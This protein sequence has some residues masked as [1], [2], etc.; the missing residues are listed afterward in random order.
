MFT[1]CR[2]KSWLVCCAIII[3]L[4]DWTLEPRELGDHIFKVL[5]VGVQLAEFGRY[6]GPALGSVRWN[7]VALGGAVWICAAL[8]FRVAHPS[9]PDFLDERAA[10]HQSVNGF[11]TGTRWGNTFDA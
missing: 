8:V 2:T 5:L 6:T 7:V 1:V 9:D 3:K 10:R 11:A 4:I